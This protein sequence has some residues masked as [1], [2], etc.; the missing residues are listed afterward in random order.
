MA[1][2]VKNGKR[3]SFSTVKKSITGIWYSHFL[4]GFLLPIM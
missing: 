2:F 3:F 4:Q 1:S